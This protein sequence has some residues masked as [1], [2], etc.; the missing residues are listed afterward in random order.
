MQADDRDDLEQVT[1]ARLIQELSSR[2]RYCIFAGATKPTDTSLA[3]KVFYS[4][5]PESTWHSLLGLLTE[6]QHN[7]MRQKQ[8]TDRNYKETF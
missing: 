5:N 7:L 8:E 4:Q 3:T 2:Y 1:T 6:A